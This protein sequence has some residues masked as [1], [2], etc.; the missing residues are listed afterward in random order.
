MSSRNNRWLVVKLLLFA[1]FS[2]MNS[3]A[4]ENEIASPLLLQWSNFV[5]ETYRYILSPLDGNFVRVEVQSSGGTS[6]ATTNQFSG[7]I[8]NLLKL[9]VRAVDEISK[10]QDRIPVRKTKCKLM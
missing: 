2:S 6:I 4:T 10:N 1:G 9:A 5:G 7:G 8:S 3:V